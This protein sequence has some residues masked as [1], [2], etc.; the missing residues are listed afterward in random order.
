MLFLL[1]NIKGILIFLPLKGD[2]FC[3]VEIL[4]MVQNV[5]YVWKYFLY[6]LV[7]NGGPK[8]VH[9]ATSVR[10][11]RFTNAFKSS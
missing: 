4:K 10:G 8:I 11:T 7:C 3:N 2:S 6:V 9:Y 1:S 5:D